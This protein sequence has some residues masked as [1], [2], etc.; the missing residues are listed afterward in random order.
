MIDN[1]QYNQCAEWR[2]WDLHEYSIVSDNFSG[3]W[4]QFKGQL[5]NTDYKKTLRGEKGVP[6]EIYRINDKGE[7]LADGG[8]KETDLDYLREIS[9]H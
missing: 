8:A 1:K 6:N 5:K 7:V 9:W 4:Y 2:K 3:T